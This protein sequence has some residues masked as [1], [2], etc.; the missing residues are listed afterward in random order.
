MLSEGSNRHQGDVFTL[1]ALQI[2]PG[3]FWATVVFPVGKRG[4]VTLDGIPNDTARAMRNSVL[5]VISTIRDHQRKEALLKYLPTLIKPVL[6]WSSKVFTACN[7]Q[8]K[9]KGWL[10]HEF[11]IK[12]IQSKPRELEAIIDEAIILNYLEAQPENIQNA[13]K[14]WKLNFDEYADSQNQAHLKNEMKVHKEFLIGLK[15]HH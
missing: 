8:L 12:V 11:K 15:N 7:A 6:E 1:E 5:R 13:I 14:F 9:V 3:A 10:T 4:S 2:I